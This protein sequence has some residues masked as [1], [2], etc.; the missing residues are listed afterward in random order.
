MKEELSSVVGSGTDSYQFIDV[1]P[2]VYLCCCLLRGGGK[3]WSEDGA[4][5]RV[6]VREERVAEHG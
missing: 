5:C 2:L 4:L 6:W 1:R 3:A